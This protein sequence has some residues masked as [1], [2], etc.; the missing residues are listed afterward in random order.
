MGIGAIV[1]AVAGGVGNYFAAKDAQKQANKNQ[2]RAEQHEINILKNQVQWRTQDAIAAGLHP[3]AALGLNPASSGVGAGQVFGGPDY[4]AMGADVGRALESMSK[5]EEKVVSQ[6]LQLQF[7]KQSL[8]NEFVKTQVASQ[9]MRNAQM[10]APAKPAVESALN[11]S[12]PPSG[13]DGVRIPFT[14]TVIPFADKG[15]AQRVEDSWGEFQAELYG[16]GSSLE[17][18]YRYYNLE[19]ALLGDAYTPTM[20]K[21]A[22]G[23]GGQPDFSNAMGN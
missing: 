11:G 13:P 3:L 16:L 4:Q 2:R 22:P 7:E 5:P 21:S 18:Y 1:G 17:S 15:V 12:L 6:A 20:F 10:A 9:R 14:D 8:E 19:K 23:V